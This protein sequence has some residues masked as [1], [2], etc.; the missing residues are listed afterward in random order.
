M[1]YLKKNNI[2]NVIL[3][4][5]LKG[6]PAQG[7]CSEVEISNWSQITSFNKNALNMIVESIEKHFSKP[8]KICYRTIPS[9][10]EMRKTMKELNLKSGDLNDP[11]VKVSN[12]DLDIENMLNLKPNV[13]EKHSTKGMWNQ[14]I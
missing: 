13:Y 14:K 3:L 6:S 12:L 11:L 4:F 10:S 2:A 5:K 7:T 9:D 8:Y 1:F